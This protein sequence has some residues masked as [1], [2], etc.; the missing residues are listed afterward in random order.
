MERVAE[1]PLTAAILALDQ[2][3]AIAIL[4]LAGWD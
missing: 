4:I 1:N 2:A 3:Q